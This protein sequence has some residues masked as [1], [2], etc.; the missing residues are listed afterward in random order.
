[1]FA[2]PDGTRVPAVTAAEMAAV[3][4]A[5]EA[6][7]L[8]VVM[9]ME[10]AG[11][12][13]A[14]AVRETASSGAVV[15]LAGG[16]GNGGGGLCAARHLANAGGAVRV[17]LDRAPADLT[18]AA[19]TQHRVL[20]TTDATV[21]TDEAALAEAAVVVDA[22]VGYGLTDALRGRPAALVEAIPET[23]TVSLDVPS[24]VDA[25]TGVAA[26]LAVTPDR[27][28]TLALPKRGLATVGGALELADLGIP[29]G[30]YEEAGVEPVAPFGGALRVPLR[31]I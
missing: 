9:M 28:L 11:R 12:A 30:V 10:S 20:K 17:V 15:V 23:P 6:R 24:G 16:G 7:G 18:G 26:G 13:L 3:D 27:T 31:R 19:A 5:A 29:A 21:G 8:A 1:V 14:G 2:T 25:D 22:L 4:R